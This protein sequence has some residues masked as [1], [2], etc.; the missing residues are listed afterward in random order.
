M[1]EDLHS[2]WDA[3]DAVISR[4]RGMIR[5]EPAWRRV[6]HL[7]LREMAE[8]NIQYAEIRSSLPQVLIA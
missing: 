3:F 6:V 7:A 5:Y 1:Y 4:V 2:S 8:D